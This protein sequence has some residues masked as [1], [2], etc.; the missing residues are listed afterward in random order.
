[1]KLT[2]GELDLLGLAA[3]LRQGLALPDEGELV[4]ARGEVAV[5]AVLRDR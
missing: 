1:V 5:E 4:A 2:I 3:G